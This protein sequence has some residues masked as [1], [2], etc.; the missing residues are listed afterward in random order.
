VQ[1]VQS[2]G[3]AFGT[4]R[5]TLRISVGNPS[6]GSGAVLNTGKEQAISASGLNWAQP[7]NRQTQGGGHVAAPPL[8]EQQLGL[9]G[10]STIKV[11]ARRS[12]V[13]FAAMTLLLAAGIAIEA[14]ALWHSRNVKRENVMRDA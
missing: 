12:Y 13:L 10:I 6:T 5:H 4:G 8:E 9:P 2:L 11:E 3:A 14:W 1:V 7:K